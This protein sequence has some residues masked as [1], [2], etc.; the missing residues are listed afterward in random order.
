[1]AAC[2]DLQIDQGTDVRVPIAFMDDFS[3]VNLTGFQARMEVR[4][5]ASNSQVVDLLTTENGRIVILDETMTL[6][7]SHSQT[8]KMASGRYVYDLE[9]ISKSG[10][11]TRMLSG[12]IDVSR[13]VTRWPTTAVATA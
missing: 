2:L 9:I 13:E 10:E 7:W 8:E 3:E 5:S 6:F 4:K 12:R 1:M 11:V